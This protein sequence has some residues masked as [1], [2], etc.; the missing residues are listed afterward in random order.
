M[1]SSLSPDA[2]RAIAQ[3]VALVLAELA[4]RQATQSPPGREGC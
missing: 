3:I 2:R 1:K 4:R